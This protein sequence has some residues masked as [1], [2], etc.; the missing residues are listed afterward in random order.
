MGGRIC[1]FGIFSLIFFGG[2]G[3]TDFPPQMNLSLSLFFWGGGRVMIYHLPK[4][5]PYNFFGRQLEFLRPSWIVS[6]SYISAKLCPL[7]LKLYFEY[8]APIYKNKY[9]VNCKIRKYPNLLKLRQ[10]EVVKYEVFSG[11]NV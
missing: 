10:I 2:R 6:K 8:R 5:L 1:N 11:R 3:A 9:K 7:H 4:N